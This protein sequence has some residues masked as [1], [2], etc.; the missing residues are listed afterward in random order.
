MSNADVY[1]K[2]TDKVVNILESAVKENNKFQWFK[3]WKTGYS[4]LPMNY[5]TKKEYSGSNILFLSLFTS[6]AGFEHPIFLTFNQI[7]KLGGTVKK[8]SSSFPVIYFSTYEKEITNNDGEA[9]KKELFIA[10]YY[11][12]FNVEQVSGIDFK[13]KTND[14]K[15]IDFELLLEPQSIWDNWKNKPNYQEKVQQAFYNPSSDLIN[16]PI[17]ESF[18]S[19]EEYYST[20]F[21]E[22]VHSTGHTSRLNRGLTEIENLNRNSYSK[23]ELI[24]ELGS[25]FLSSICGIDKTF[26]NSVAYLQGWIKSLKND[27]K[28]IFQASSRAVEAVNMISSK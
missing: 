18:N 3:P 21:H 1:Q 27:I 22:A 2:I 14:I 9:E 20:L 4:G 7:K 12:V 16:M 5:T 25:A 17:K 19:S 10:K 13:I 24:A 6:I 28:L 8:G 15:Q 23:E 26:D 11:N